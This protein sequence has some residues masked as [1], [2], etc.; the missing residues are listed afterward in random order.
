M[1][2]TSVER[3]LSNETLLKV[4]GSHFACMTCKAT[5]L[6]DSYYKETNTVTVVLCF[7]SSWEKVGALVFQM[8]FFIYAVNAEMV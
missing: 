4:Q 3:G 6:T 8:S 5:A 7:K 1:V 2:V